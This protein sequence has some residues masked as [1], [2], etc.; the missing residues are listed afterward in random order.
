[1]LSHVDGIKSGLR[2]K[3]DQY[4]IAKK[5]YLSYPTRVFAELPEIEFA[6]KNEVSRKYGI[7][8]GSVAIVGS[9]K[10]GFSFYKDRAFIKGDSD[11]DISVVDSILFSQFFEESHIVSSGYTDNTVFGQT[12]GERHDFQFKNSL[13]KGYIN[14]VYMPYCELRREW[15][16]LFNRLSNKYIDFFKTI[17]GGL[18][19]SEYFFVAKQTDCIDRYKSNQKYYDQ[20]SGTFKGID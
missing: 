18:Y 12:K 15:L 8:F 5:I 13:L 6:I 16:A 3:E 1:M 20:I 2:K 10:T 19:S 4:T 14:P 11:L 17:N 9:S 7:P